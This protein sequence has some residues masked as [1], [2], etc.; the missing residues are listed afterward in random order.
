MRLLPIFAAIFLCLFAP[1]ALQAGDGPA[2]ADATDDALPPGA[3]A[4][5]GTTRL[6]QVDPSFCIAFAPDGKTFATGGGAGPITFW[7][8]KTGR[9]TKN[10]RAHERTVSCLLFMPDGKRL[11]SGG[12]DATVRIWDIENARAFATIPTKAGPSSMVLLPDG[13]TLAVAAGS[14]KLIDLDDE[15]VVGEMT[16]RPAEKDAG[17]PT[18]PA[19]S[20]AIT[21]DGKTLI[22]GHQRGRVTFWDLAERKETDRLQLGADLASLNIIA[23]SHDGKTL[24][25]PEP[26]G[27]VH[28]MNLA[29]RKETGTLTGHMQWVTSL[30]F[31][32]D[33]STLATLAGDG[34]VRVWDVAAR[35]QKLQLPSAGNLMNALAFSPDDK[36]LAV[37]RVDKVVGLYSLTTGKSVFE[38]DGH[39]DQIYSLAFSADGA[40]LYSGAVTS[41]S[42]SDN[43]LRKWDVASRKLVWTTT[44]PTGGIRQLALSAD[45]KRLATAGGDKT[46]HLWEESTGKQAATMPAEAA[47]VMCLA[48]AKDGAILFSAG[49][50]GVWQWKEN[51]VEPAAIPATAPS[52][53]ADRSY[54]ALALSPDE[55]TLATGYGQVNLQDLATGQ[56]TT[57]AE[58]AGMVSRVKF[59]ADGALV[60]AASHQGFVRVWNA[61]SHQQLFSLTAHDPATQPSIQRQAVW[62]FA[63]SPD[64]QLLAAASGDGVVRIWSLSTGQ[65]LARLPAH[66]GSANCVAFSPN[67][68]LLAT[69]GQDA[70]IL[71]W[72]TAPWRAIP[73]TT[74]PAP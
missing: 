42:P 73:A 11:V 58:G 68:K 39:T 70:N 54:F 44:Q 35:K 51:R 27:I 57:L 72:D 34:T 32:H 26:G 48:F 61:K 31:S 4:R 23:L 60:A 25:W 63:F 19:T 24:A 15:K 16:A 6:R 69:A 17:L 36:L 5:L 59:S 65:L 62:D 38:S 18:L 52:K 56:V 12:A 64:A 7:D 14:I 47:H 22:A 49:R 33:D 8:V 13:K 66:E 41:G 43:T 10:L 3:I 74:N 67:G 50:P 20:L 9:P 55:K 40:S 53:G 37:A 21:P 45:G 29:D 71:L 2:P 28:L 30:A 1:V 46:I